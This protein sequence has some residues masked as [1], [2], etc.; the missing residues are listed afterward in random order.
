[1]LLQDQYDSILEQIAQMGFDLECIP[2]VNGLDDFLANAGATFIQGIPTFNSRVNHLDESN[3]FWYRVTR[4]GRGIACIAAKLWES[5]DLGADISTLRIWYQT[6]TN[7]AYTGTPVGNP[8]EGLSGRWSIG[9]KLFVAPEA[10]KS[11]LSTLLTVLI[12]T[13]MALE[14]ATVGHFCL[15]ISVLVGKD[16]D[17]KTY[18]YPR[19]AQPALIVKNNK[20]GE[21]TPFTA[22]WITRDEMIQTDVIG[23]G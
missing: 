10:R 6:G 11:G 9:G 15:I 17:T 21:I 1:M 3:S 12:R 23:L 13:K 2:G 18:L 22:N 8:L 4:E 20:T 16:L 14:Y 5:D 19:K 7:G